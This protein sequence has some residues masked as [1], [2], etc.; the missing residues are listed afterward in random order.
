[1]GLF[2]K[3]FG[4]SRKEV[5]VDNIPGKSWD[6]DALIGI[7]LSN[8][9]SF[10][11]FTTRDEIKRNLSKEDLLKYLHEQCEFI[12]PQ[13]PVEEIRRRKSHSVAKRKLPDGSDYEWR[14]KLIYIGSGFYPVKISGRTQ[15][16]M[17]GVVC[18]FG[19][20]HTEIVEELRKTGYFKG[21]WEALKEN[22]VT[23]AFRKMK[24]SLFG[25]REEDNDDDEIWR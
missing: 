1:M 21:E 19:P 7:G 3:L 17:P 24:E 8:D 15:I 18:D 14:I 2:D 22:S 5:I 12:E 16:F 10:G 11:E 4:S 13:D 20:E 9:V 23:S 25:S 6:I